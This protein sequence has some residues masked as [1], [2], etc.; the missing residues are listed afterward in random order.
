MGNTK[1]DKNFKNMP[2]K[3]KLVS[4]FGIIIVTTFILILTLL[5]G[6]KIIGVI[7]HRTKAVMA[8]H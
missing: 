6:M 1:F 3:K 7:Q 5:V 2:I 8:V 4:S